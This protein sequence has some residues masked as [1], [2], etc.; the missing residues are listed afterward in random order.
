MEIRL[1]KYVQ[2]NLGISRRKFVDLVNAWKVFLDARKIES[3]GELLKGWET[4]EIKGTKIKKKVILSQQN[5]DLILFNKPKG[6]VCSKSDKHNK[7][8]YDIL[9]P[10]YKNYFYIGRLDKDSRGLLLMTNDSALVNKIEHPSHKVEKEY[11][12]EIDRQFSI[13]DTKK[14]KEWILDDWDLL[15][16]NKIK[17]FEEK[18]KFFVNVILLEGKKRHIRRVLNYFKYKVLD[19]QRVREWEYK[20][21]NLREGELINVSL[22]KG[23]KSRI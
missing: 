4:L 8:I 13:L 9:S 22:N 6:V 23:N 1:N 21:N 7:T 16:I 20:L 18:N 3:Y 5:S 2:E 12:V 10:K 17:F 14:M 11:V 15:K 19:L